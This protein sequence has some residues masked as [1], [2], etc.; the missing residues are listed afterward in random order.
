MLCPRRLLTLCELNRATLAR[1]LLLD[2]EAL[3]VSEAV[4][5]LVGLQAEVPN[6]PYV[7]LW[8][9]LRDFRRDDFTGLMEEWRVVRATFLVDGFVSGTWKIEKTRRAAILVIEPFEYLP[10]KDRDV[11]IEEGERLVRFVESGAEAS[12][13]RFAEEV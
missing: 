11:L 10:K 6:P 12:E 4:E 1:Q 2:R 9:R 7:G 13:V 3:P 8:T 5:R